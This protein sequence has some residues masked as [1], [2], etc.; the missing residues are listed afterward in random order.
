MVAT[1]L[2]FLARA[3]PVVML[4]EDG[5]ARIEPVG[6]D[7]PGDVL[8]AVRGDPSAPNV[9]RGPGR[10]TGTGLDHV[11]RLAGF[12]VAIVGTL[13][14]APAGTSDPIESVPNRRDGRA[15]VLRRN[16]GVAAVVVFHVVAR[17]VDVVL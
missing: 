7:T 9:V 11:R 1:L 15:P 3:P 16:E 12:H 17:T 6:D 8:A 13:G 14:A 2:G 10:G 5:V 4:V